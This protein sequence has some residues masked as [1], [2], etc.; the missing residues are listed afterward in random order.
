LRHPK[1]LDTP[2]LLELDN[3]S[4][5]RGLRPALHRVSLRI[6]QGEHTAILGPNGS[7]KSTLIKVITREEYPRY[8]AESSLRILGREAWRVDDLRSMLGIVT[9]DLVAACT[10][11]YPAREIVL[12]GF[13]SAVGIWPW[14]EVSA[15]MER[16]ADE[17]LAFVGLSGLAERPMTEM[18]SGE[19]RRAV[20]A[21]AL[22]HRPRALLLDEPSNSLD[23]VAF[24]E[25]QATMRRLA[26]SGITVVLVT[27][28]LADIIPEISRVICLKKGR[29]Y[30]DGPKAE[31]LR[32]E[33]LSPLFGV[34]VRVMADNGHYA[35][36]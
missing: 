29:V 5:W 7:G 1:E 34:D 30:R 10:Q 24:R 18:S 35:M 9:N 11:P 2:P 26:A 4:V 17:A 14:H 27:H 12:S 33:T 22:A 15:E 16:A 13:F 36:W 8:P 25:L 20:I 31:I 23:I 19:V 21:R 6:A 3:V 32:A 28:H